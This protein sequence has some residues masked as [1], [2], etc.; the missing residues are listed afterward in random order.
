MKISEILEGRIPRK[1][2]QP[3][4]NEA[5]QLPSAPSLNDEPE[6]EDSEAGKEEG[7]EEQVT[8][9]KKYG[10]EFGPDLYSFSS[11][12]YF[13]DWNARNATGL[14]VEVQIAVVEAAAT[15]VKVMLTMLL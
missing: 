5:S 2:W 15:A 6:D 9:F 8:Q 7:F 1:Y 4:A 10:A 3:H 13:G 14:S 12:E 11:I